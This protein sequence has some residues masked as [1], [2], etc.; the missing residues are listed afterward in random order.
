[1][2]RHVLFRIEVRRGHSVHRHNDVHVFQGRISRGVENGALCSRADDDNRLDPLIRENFA[3]IRADKLVGT[4]FDHRIRRMRGEISGNV[5]RRA[6]AP[7]AINNQNLFCSCLGEHLLHN[8]YRLAALD[9][10]AVGDLP[11]WNIVFGYAAAG[12]LLAGLTALAEPFDSTAPATIASRLTYLQISLLAGAVLFSTSAASNTDFVAWGEVFLDAVG[13][14]ATRAALE[15]VPLFWAILSS[16]FLM[17]AGGM[18]LSCDPR[19]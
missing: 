3:E 19:R 2:P 18:T 13:T 6:A 4:R 1:M 14:A 10:C 17:A 12:V 9:W 15:Q 11:F 7:E 8:R 5:G 16:G